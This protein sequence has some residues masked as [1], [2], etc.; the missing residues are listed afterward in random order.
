[1]KIAATIA[2]VLTALATIA[3]IVYIIATYGDKIVAWAKNLGNHAKSLHK[4][5]LLNKYIFCFHYNQKPGKK[6]QGICETI[7]FYKYPYMPRMLTS[8]EVTVP[9]VPSENT[10]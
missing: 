6:Q 8:P 5:Y 10:T 1:M 2:K 3:G 4:K 9:V 7:K